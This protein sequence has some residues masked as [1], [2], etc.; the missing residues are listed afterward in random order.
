MKKLLYFCSVL[1]SLQAAAQDDGEVQEN[2]TQEETLNEPAPP[3]VEGEGYDVDPDAFFIDHKVMMGEKIFMISK[4]YMVDPFEIY[5]YNDATEGVEAGTILK[6]PLHKSKKRDLDAFKAQL[7]KQNGGQPI[8]V[9][10]PPPR[11]KKPIDLDDK[12]DDSGW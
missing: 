7:V 3:M 4:K 9:P 6:I 10:A 12:K 11:E 5:K 1:L 8:Q 2:G